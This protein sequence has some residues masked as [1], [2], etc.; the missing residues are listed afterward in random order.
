MTEE[1][2]PRGRPRKN[3]VPDANVEKRPRGRPAKPEPEPGSQEEMEAFQRSFR[4]YQAVRKANKVYYE[5]HKEEIA[6][7]KIEKS[8]TRSGVKVI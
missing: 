4:H 7:R 2:K 1:K 6:R 5:R 3:P 8:Q